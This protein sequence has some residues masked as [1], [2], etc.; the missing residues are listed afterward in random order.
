MNPVMSRIKYQYHPLARKNQKKA[1]KV[2]TQRR[3]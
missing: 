1:G 2:K 3:K